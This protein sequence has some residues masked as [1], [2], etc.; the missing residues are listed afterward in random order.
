[1][2]VTVKAKPFV[3]FL[4]F[5]ILLISSLACRP[6]ITIGW[7]EIGI[8]LIILVAL[9]GPSL[10]KFYKRFDEFKNWKND[11]NDDKT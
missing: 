10:F 9:L 3:F 2:D 1:M 11:K 4:P 5:A 8:L 7:Q 6:I